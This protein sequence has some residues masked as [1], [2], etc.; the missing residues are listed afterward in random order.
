MTDLSNVVQKAFY[1]GVGIASYA[2]Q[3]A[4]EK[5]QDLTNQATKLA[6]EM[7]ERGEMTTE[8]AKKFVDD[9]VKQAQQQT[10]EQHEEEQKEKEPRPIEILDE[11]ESKQEAKNVDSL[12]EQVQ[13]LQDEL[14]RLK[15]D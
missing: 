12:R 15:R 5:L 10:V 9:I 7:I 2:N 8:E 4:T 1:L 3:K 13:S 14:R 6:Q 11:E